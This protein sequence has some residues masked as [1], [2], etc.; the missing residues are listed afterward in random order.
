MRTRQRVAFIFLVSLLS[1]SFSSCLKRPPAEVEMMKFPLDS[2]DGLLTRSGVEFDQNISVDSR[3]SVKIS[4]TE[5]TIIRLFELGDLDVEEAVLVYKAKLRTE[6]AEGF[7]YLEMLCHFEGKGEFF[8]RG[9]NSPL[10]GSVEWTS[11]EIPFFLKKEENPDNIKLNIVCEGPGVV[12]VDDI[13]LV[14]RKLAE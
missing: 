12:W 5:P 14:K 11:Q 7:V 4:V 2:L 13:R 3:G 8:S 9:L 1:I 10:K 6:G